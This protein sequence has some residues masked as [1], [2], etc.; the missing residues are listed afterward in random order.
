M[1]VV[2]SGSVL[3][4]PLPAP[5]GFIGGPL[6]AAAVKRSHKVSAALSAPVLLGEESVAVAAMMDREPLTR[7]TPSRLGK[8]KS[9]AISSDGAECSLVGR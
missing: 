2:K 3:A 9:A 7:P 8:F 6:E 4:S 5:L 1:S